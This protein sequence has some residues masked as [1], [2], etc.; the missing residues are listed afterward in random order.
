M[1][2]VE[3]VLFVLFTGCMG[4]DQFD[5]ISKNTPY[6]DRLQGKR[7]KTRPIAENLRDVFGE[8]F[9]IRW[10]LPLPPSTQARAQFNQ[11][12]YDTIDHLE[13]SSAEYQNTLNGG[14]PNAKLDANGGSSILRRRNGSEDMRING[15]EEMRM[16]APARRGSLADVNDNVNV[17]PRSSRYG[18]PEY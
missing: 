11:M 9:S 8:P 2:F 14:Q 18:D 12:C 17:G 3:A 1:N 10:F 15:S 16:R 13:Q 6:I 7:G 4:A 5:A